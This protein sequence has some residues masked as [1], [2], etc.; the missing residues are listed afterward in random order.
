MARR[1]FFSERHCS[2]I[3]V[4]AGGGCQLLDFVSR[5]IAV[6]ICISVFMCACLSTRGSVNVC[7]LCASSW[8][9]M[10]APERH[11]WFCV[12]QGGVGVY[13]P[14]PHHCGLNKNQLFVDKHVTRAHEPAFLFFYKNSLFLLYCLFR[15]R[16]SR[17]DARNA[18]FSKNAARVHESA[19]HRFGRQV[20]HFSIWC[21]AHSQ[22]VGLT[23]N[24]G[25]L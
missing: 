9:G 13:T 1:V 12:R 20:L 18:H 15:S 4:V 24:T 14:E 17:L 7:E 21:N 11:L 3:W 16:C 25:N 6:C 2:K 10:G 5:R 8:L 23:W 19:L 22:L